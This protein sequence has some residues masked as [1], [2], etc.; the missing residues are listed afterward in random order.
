MSLT[1]INIYPRK[2]KWWMKFMSSK[3][4]YSILVHIIVA[5]AN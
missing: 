4:V 1:T 5:V 2:L 3:L